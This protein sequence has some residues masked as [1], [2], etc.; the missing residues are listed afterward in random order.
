M[1]PI[2]LESGTKKVFAAALN[3]PGWSRSGRDEAEA[4]AAL[5]EYGPRYARAVM[6]TGLPFDIPATVADFT[7][8]ERLPLSLIHI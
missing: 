8:V 3:W 1:T 7:I 4:L 2:Y 5:L 6:A